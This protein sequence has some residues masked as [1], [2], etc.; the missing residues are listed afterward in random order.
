MC[1]IIV[2]DF[3]LNSFFLWA[4][5]YLFSV[6]IVNS[7]AKKKTLLFYHLILNPISRFDTK[8]LVI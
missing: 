4:G 6:Y 5:Y 1:L 8:Y 7:L 2:I 3:L